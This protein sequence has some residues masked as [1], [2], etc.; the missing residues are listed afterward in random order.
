MSTTLTGEPTTGHGSA[1]AP[2]RP[3]APLVLYLSLFF[4]VWALRATVLFFLDESI[5][6]DFG[7]AVYSNAVKLLVWVLPAFLYL[8]LYERRRPL[9]YLKLSTR[10]AL[11]GDALAAPPSV[12]FFSAVVVFE[13][14]TSGRNLESLYKASAPAVGLAL[15]SVSVSPL[16]EEIMFRGFV[17]REFWE[18]TGFLRGDVLPSPL[19]SLAHGPYGLWENGLRK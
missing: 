3:T 18:P 7:K 8:K 11:S 10:P 16:L 4:C 17:L 2:K 15:L 14:F 9:R 1:T 6:T 13:R 5:R 12:L 19:S